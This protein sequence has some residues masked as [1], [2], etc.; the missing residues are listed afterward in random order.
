MDRYHKKPELEHMLGHLYERH[1]HHGK[2]G[3][4]K[5]R[6]KIF[7]DGVALS[8]PLLAAFSWYIHLIFRSMAGAGSLQLSPGKAEPIITIILVFIVCY[9]VFLMVEY[10]LLFKKLDKIRKRKK[11]AT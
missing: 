3:E 2:D 9:S 5:E 7:A 8:L 6:W 4:A 10:N 11:S 1:G